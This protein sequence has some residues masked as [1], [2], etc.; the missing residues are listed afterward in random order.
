MSIVPT[1]L[2]NNSQKMLSL[3]SQ[4]QQMLADN[5]IN[6][7]TQGYRRKDIDF[8]QYLNSGT[9]SSLEER[10]I[11]K[12]G[13]SPIASNSKSEETISPEQELSLMQQNYMLYNVA[14]RNLSSTI[15]QIKT[16]L[17]VSA[18]G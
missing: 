14:V 15:T 1:E 16:A 6:M 7:H 9:A 18:N 12:F 13:V 17:N 11:E 8:S 2:L 4:R 10:M 5:I 3:V